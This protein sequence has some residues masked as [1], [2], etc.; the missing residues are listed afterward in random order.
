MKISHDARQWQQIAAPSHTGKRLIIGRALCWQHLLDTVFC[1]S[2]PSM[3]IKH[4]PVCIFCF[5]GEEEGNYS[6]DATQDNC[7]L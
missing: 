4:L 6:R 7:Q 1:V 2:H 3:S 5:W